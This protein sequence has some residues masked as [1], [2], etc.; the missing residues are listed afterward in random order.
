M[1]RD[2]NIASVW[3]GA[4]WMGKPLI[5]VP[6]LALA[7]VSAGTNGGDEAE[8]RPAGP[9]LGGNDASQKFPQRLMCGPNSLYILLALHGMSVDHGV[10]EKCI[11]SHSEGMSLSELRD[12]SNA[13]GL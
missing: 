2:K 8:P 3:T 4:T 5:I 7:G 1:R 9:V 11:P 6:L 13:L 10:I 12:A